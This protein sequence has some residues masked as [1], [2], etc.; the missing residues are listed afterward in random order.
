[1]AWTLV[2]ATAGARPQARLR[3]GFTAAAGKLYVHGGQG[4]L[5]GGGECDI[6]PRLR[7]RLQVDWHGSGARRWQKLTRLDFSLD[8]HSKRSQ[9]IQCRDREASEIK[10]I[11]LYHHMFY[12]KNVIAN[13]KTL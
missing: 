9:K 5:N 8:A 4:A 10:F 11:T 7:R 3:H 13:S 6:L 12:D 1:M 2:S